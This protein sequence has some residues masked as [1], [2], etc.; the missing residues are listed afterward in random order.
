[1]Q[2]LRNQWRRLQLKRPFSRRIRLA[3]RTVLDPEE[4]NS[5]LVAL[6][7]ISVEEP[8]ENSL[9]FLAAVYGGRLDEATKR[10]D[11]IRCSPFVEA[12]RQLYHES[13]FRKFLLACFRDYLHSGRRLYQPMAELLLEFARL[14]DPEAGRV[15]A[16][17]PRSTVQPQR[18]P[19]SFAVSGSIPRSLRVVVMIRRHYFGSESRLHDIGPRFKTAF[20]DQ[21]WNCD[22][23][24]PLY[25][26]TDVGPADLVLVED[27]HLRRYVFR[28]DIGGYTD[29]LTRLRRRGARLGLVELDPWATR[30]E[31]RL[32]DEPKLYDFVWTMAPGMVRDG[33]IA[34]IAACVMPFPV[35]FGRLFEEVAGQATPAA[36]PPAFVGGVEEYNFHR[37]FWMLA[38]MGFRQPLAFEVTSHAGQAMSAEDSARAYLA[39]LTA[40][41]ACLSFTMRANGQRLVVGRAFD[42]L[43][44]G[45][46]LVQEWSSDMHYYF[47]SGTHYVEF[48]TPEELE[49]ISL[50]LRDHPET[51]SDIRAA[52]AD[53]F[54]ANY[55]DRAVARHLTTF[56]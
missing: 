37:Y 4:S 41:P 34:G 36:G 28:K 46:L 30:F 52:G 19:L 18:Q 47:Q 20:D 14:T 15:L 13:D 7:P 5:F 38:G 2:L 39:K 50:R 53:F 17:A 35:G 56:L 22:L 40:A 31:V 25:D 16:P 3:I 10:L 42:V 33:S 11:G 24:D 44:A 27:Q 51:Y 49:D 9:A 8:L 6:G 26:G 54:A 32:R 29:L 43:R 23:I 45:R 48:A 12:Y 55:C 1:M 21:G